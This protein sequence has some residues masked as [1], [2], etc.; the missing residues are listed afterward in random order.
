MS[1]TH[2]KNAAAKRRSATLKSRGGGLGKS[3]GGGRKHGKEPPM[4]D[5]TMTSSSGNVFEDIG[6]PPTEAR[7]LL[8]RA[9]LVNSIERLIVRRKLTQS[10]AAKLFGVTQPRVSDLMRGK[11]D[12]F[13]ID[14][15]IAMLGRAG[16]EVG[17]TFHPRAA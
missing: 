12:L 5:Q 8:L 14:T 15:L 17:L 9:D 11:I 16:V 4:P 3:S 2:S 10:Q 7:N 1:F 13:S 6:F